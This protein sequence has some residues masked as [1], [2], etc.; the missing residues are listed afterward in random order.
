MKLHIYAIKDRATDSFGNPMFFVA[1]GQAIRS[2][3]DE[4][5]R[6]DAQNMIYAHPDDFDL[7]ELGTFETD[8]GKFETKTPELKTRG[9]EIKIRDNG[10]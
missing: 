3:T 9:K 5:N 10:K 2:F 8:T 6:Q 7:Y 1:S 4:A